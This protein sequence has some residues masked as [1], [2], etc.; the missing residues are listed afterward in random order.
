LADA[1]H[2]RIVLVTGAAAGI[3][4]AIALAFKRQGDVVFAADL[5]A[6]PYAGADPSGLVPVQTD[7]TDESSVDALFETIEAHAGGV[8]VLVNAAGILRTGAVANVSRVDWADVMRVNLEAVFFVSQRVV[9]GM[10]RRH[11]GGAIINIASTSALV[12][13]P[14]Q[15]VYEISKAGVMA[16]TRALALELAPESIRVNA[17]APGLVDTGMTRRLFGTPDRLL[18]RAREKVPLG[19]AGSAHD[20]AEIAV[21]LASPAADYIIGQMIVADGGW[22]LL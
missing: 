5:A 8:D 6:R 13:A 14:D 21:F 11:V 20:I 15:S 12:S 4:H 10:R 9:A 19:R 1:A 17:I 7:V 22:L 18:A 2:P 3:G 16:L